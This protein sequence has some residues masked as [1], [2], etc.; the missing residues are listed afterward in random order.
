MLEEEGSVYSNDEDYF[1]DI[2]RGGQ[3]EEIKEFVE[4]LPQNSTFDFTCIT[5]DQN[6]FLRRHNSMKI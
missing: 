1:L 6:S 4:T 3:L 5:N 2:C